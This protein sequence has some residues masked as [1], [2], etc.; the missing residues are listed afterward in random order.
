MVPI[1]YPSAFVS[2]IAYAACS[3]ERQSIQ[4]HG[5]S[6]SSVPGAIGATHHYS[7]LVAVFFFSLF[8]VPLGGLHS[9]CGTFREEN[10]KT[11]TKKLAT[12]MVPRAAL[13]DV[14]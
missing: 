12:A 13:H 5:S 6:I 7:L 8:T 9:V 10:R 3:S 1:L 2:F 4:L 14:G 11:F